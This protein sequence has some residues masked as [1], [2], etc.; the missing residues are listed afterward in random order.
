M[1]SVCVP[2]FQADVRPLARQLSAMAAKASFPV[3]ILLFDDSSEASWEALHAE[4]ASLPGISWRRLEKNL[5]RATIRNL[6]GR[7]AHYPWL[8]FLD[9]DSL[10][11]ST[12]FLEK[13]AALTVSGPV[14]CGGTLYRKTPPEDPGKLL[15][16]TYGRKREERTAARREKEPGFALTANNFLIRRDLFLQHPFR[17]TITG[18]GHEDTV[19][20]YDLVQAGIPLR[21][22]D[23]PVY[24][25]GLESSAS[26]LEKSRAAVGN[27][28]YLSRHLIRDPR[29]DEASPLLRGLG[30]L[31]RY[32]LLGWASR[33]FR[34]A[35]PLLHKN[36][37][38]PHPSLLL[39]DLY[40]AGTLCTLAHDK[41]KPRKEKTPD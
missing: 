17:E 22:T 21:H 39:F 10:A 34:V 30:R 40:R 27:L 38:G 16:W 13:Y 18:Y 25:T 24:H 33:L 9:A 1:I 36:L 2:I 7:E 19:L 5:G 26:Y 28:Y 37:T 32:G 12:D 20:G 15:R 14:W 35:K 29:F 6:L 11:A 31:Q 3:E 4:A 41:G 23:N 8:L